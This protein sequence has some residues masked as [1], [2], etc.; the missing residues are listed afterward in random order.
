H[1]HGLQQLRHPEHG[2]GRAAACEWIHGSVASA[3]IRDQTA[4]GCPRQACGRYFRRI[5]MNRRHFLATAAAGVAVGTNAR[6]AEDPFVGR[7]RSELPTPAL[8]VN[9][10][11]FEGNIRK[12]ADH[13]KAAGCGFR[14]HAKTHKCP[15]IAKR[16]VAA[17]ALGVCVATVPEAEAMAAS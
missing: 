5:T 4:D 17:G 11:V 15:E 6:A 13:C 8:L 10:D 12:M 2:R 14:P 7:T 1:E 9:L 16:Q 3:G